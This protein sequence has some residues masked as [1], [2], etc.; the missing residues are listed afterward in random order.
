M[1]F[2]LRLCF[3]PYE[4][5]WRGRGTQPCPSTWKPRLRRRPP[6]SWGDAACRFVCRPCRTSHTSLR[7]HLFQSY[8]HN[9]LSFILYYHREEVE[10]S[11]DPSYRVVRFEVI[12]QSFSFA[13][14]PCMLPG[15]G[16][17]AESLWGKGMEEGGVLM[18]LL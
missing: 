11:Q 17:R 12:P 6:S 5:A 2:Y 1:T 13:G 8:L 7:V 10:G 9:H 16:A 4:E 3:S 14:K 18:V 15:T